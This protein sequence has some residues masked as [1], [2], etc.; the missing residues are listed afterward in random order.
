LVDLF[1]YMM[2]HGLTNL[3]IVSLVWI[4]SIWEVT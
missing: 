4:A 2:T 1:E 3:K